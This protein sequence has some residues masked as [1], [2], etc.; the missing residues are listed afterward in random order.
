MYSDCFLAGLPCNAWGGC[1]FMV[2][3]V[4]RAVLQVGAK[5][6]ARHGSYAVIAIAYRNLAVAASW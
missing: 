5:L 2:A 3:L 1:P 6:H 4:F